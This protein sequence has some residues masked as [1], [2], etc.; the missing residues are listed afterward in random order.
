MAGE[1]FNDFRLSSEIIDLDNP[2]M[3]CKNWADHPTGTSG[4]VGGFITDGFLI[5][6]G[7]TSFNGDYTD[8]CHLVGPNFADEVEAR[9]N[10]PT[11]E[12]G[13]V[14]VDYSTLVVTGGYGNIRI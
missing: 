6:S 2:R 11:I 12:S 5:C 3:K 7:E 14:M 9:L 13:A 8:K 1:G 10:R 4:A